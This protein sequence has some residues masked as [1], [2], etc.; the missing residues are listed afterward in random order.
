MRKTIIALFA[1]IAPTILGFSLLIPQADAAVIRAN[2]TVTVSSEEKGLAD[3][4]LFGNSITVD[5]PVTNDIVSAGGDIT[6]NGNV[7]GSV[8]AAGGNVTIKGNVG[9]TIRVAGGNVIIDGKVTRDTVVAGGNLT[10]TKN[11][12]ISGDL[13]MFGGQV[14]IEGPVQGKILCNGGNVYLNSS[15]GKN[16]DGNVGKLSLGPNAI[17]NGNLTYASSEKAAISNGAVVK[18]NTQYKPV[19]N[20]HQNKQNAPQIFGFGLFYKLLADI[21][22]SILLITFLTRIVQ[23]IMLRMTQE[24]VKSGAYGFAYLILFPI[25]SFILLLLIWLGIASMFFYIVT[26][27][28]SLYLVKVF[29]GWKLMQWWEKRDK[30][31]YVLDWKA[32]VVGPIVVAIVLLIPIFGWFVIAILFFIAIGALVQNIVYALSTQKVEAPKKK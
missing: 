8:M 11:A 2:D 4:Y 10:I 15:V 5:A 30:R 25:I 31:N 17:I 3:P 7:T 9:N 6:V 12:T 20:K 1:L 24:P 14:K 19:E 18:G 22:L 27:I 28:L 16:F 23:A 21:I 13:I 26:I 29:V 32:G